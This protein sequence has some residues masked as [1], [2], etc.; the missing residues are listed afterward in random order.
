MADSKRLCSIVIIMGGLAED[1]WRGVDLFLWFGDA[2]L[3]TCISNRLCDVLVTV[4]RTLVTNVI[5]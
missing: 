1:F 4:A 5:L 3:L 2:R